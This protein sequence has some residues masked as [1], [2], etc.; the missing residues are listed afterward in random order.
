ME[1]P[2]LD[3]PARAETRLG[4]VIRRLRIP[5]ELGG[6]VYPA[7]VAR[8]RSGSGTVRFVRVVRGV[9]LGPRSADR[10]SPT[11]PKSRSSRPDA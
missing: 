3:G 6:R 7:P 5:P 11:G 1:W 2:V 10:E 9:E 8:F 4:A